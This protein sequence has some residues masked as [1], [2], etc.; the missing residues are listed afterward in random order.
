M[1]E[2]FRRRRLPHWD[3]PGATYFI[4]AC[5]FNSIP[6]QGFLDIKNVERRLQEQ[7][8]PDKMTEEEWQNQKWKL[9]FAKCD[10]WLDLRPQV[11][12]LRDSRLALEVQNSLYFHAGDH[13]DLLAYVI[14]PSHYHWLFRPRD[15]WVAKLGEAANDRSP[16]ERIMHSVQGYS[17]RICNGLLGKTGPFWQQE[18]YDHVVRDEDELHRVFDYIELNPVRRGWVT[19]REQWR[20]SSAFDRRVVAP[21]ELSQPLT[22]DVLQRV[23]A[24]P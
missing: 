2:Q 4:T 16:R 5:L 13:Y 11:N 21:T 18:S 8:R 22:K 1:K 20:F 12:H 23:R 14:M 3:V 24:T 19:H 6:A 17:G 10:E 7:Q 15:A 9:M